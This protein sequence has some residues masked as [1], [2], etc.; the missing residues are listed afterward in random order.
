MDR[1]QFLIKAGILSVMSATSPVLS[2]RPA[3]LPGKNVGATGKLNLSNEFL[4]WR[5]EWNDGKVRSSGFTNKLTNQDFQISTRHE[6]VLVFSTAKH[7]VDIPWWNFT[8]S[9]DET[10]VSP[11]AEKGLALGYHQAD[12]SEKGWGRTDNLLLRRLSGIR[13]RGDGIA[14]AGYGWFRSNFNLPNKAQG[15]QVVLGLGG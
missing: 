3:R 15:E 7:R 11:D 14:Y 9:P 4:D 2:A 1:R 5:V 12:F 8:Y 13:R 10:A 6:A